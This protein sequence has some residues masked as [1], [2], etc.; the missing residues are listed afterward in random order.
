MNCLA[1]IVLSVNQRSC[2]EFSTTSRLSLPS[3]SS[4]C[5]YKREEKRP[6]VESKNHENPRWSCCRRAKRRPSRVF[7]SIIIINTQQIFLSCFSSRVLVAAARDVFDFSE[8][9]IA[10]GKKSFF[11]WQNSTHRFESRIFTHRPIARFLLVLFS[12]FY[13]FPRWLYNNL[14]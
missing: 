3:C 14:F 5:T 4:C 13:L 12:F 9:S 2:V 7:L 11:F 8:F 6:C 1:R 10:H